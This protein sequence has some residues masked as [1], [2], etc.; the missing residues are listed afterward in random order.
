MKKCAIVTGGTKPQGRLPLK[1]L[2]E[3]DFIICADQG[4]EYAY[5]LGYTPNLILGD[6]DSV[7]QEILEKYQSLGVEIAQFPVDKDYTDTEL[8]LEKAIAQNPRE[9]Y[10]LA[11]TGDRL[12]HTFATVLALVP[13]AALKIQL[14]II[15]DNFAAWL[16]TGQSVVQGKPGDTVS[17][18]PLKSHVQGVTVEGFKY[19]LHN[20]TLYFGSSRGVSNILTAPKG[21]IV[22]PQGLLLV[23]H[24][25]ENVN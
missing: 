10:L 12:D 4:A 13:Y 8:A 11:A 19:P 18:I 25:F 5:E 9:I 7:S 6:F 16:C 21:K 14:K 17:L 2:E 22:F 23:I 15:E 20:E 3:A 1:Y 24:Y